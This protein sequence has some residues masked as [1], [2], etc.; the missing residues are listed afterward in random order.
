MLFLTEGC[1]ISL[2]ILYAL[3]RILE[4]DFV[5]WVHLPIRRPRLHPVLDVGHCSHPAHQVGNLGV[6]CYHTRFKEVLRA[7]EEEMEVGPCEG[8]AHHPLPSLLNQS[9][10]K[11]AQHSWISHLGQLHQLFFALCIP[12]LIGGIYAVLDNI[13]NL[14]HLNR[15][16]SL[17][18]F[19][20]EYLS[21]LHVG[22]ARNAKLPRKESGWMS[23]HTMLK[24]KH[25]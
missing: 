21:H 13:H 12:S 22:L 16:S 19:E 25:H 23:H 15:D 2:H 11:L 5:S 10:L 9:F 20:E 7:E 1:T 17:D 6:G 24:R 8:I 18:D 4:V 14:V 3:V